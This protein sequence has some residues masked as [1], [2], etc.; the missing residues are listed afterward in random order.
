MMC[1]GGRPLAKGKHSVMLAAVIVTAATI[2]INITNINITSC[3][4]IN[5]VP[6]DSSNF[7]TREAFEI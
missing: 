7:Q 3:I 6:C 5:L 2:I 1:S 4:R